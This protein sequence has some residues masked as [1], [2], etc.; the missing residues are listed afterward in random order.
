[1]NTINC[2]P[3]NSPWGE[4][5]EHGVDNED[6]PGAARVFTASHGGLWLGPELASQVPDYLRKYSADGNGVWWEEDCAWVL[7]TAYFQLPGADLDDVK[8]YYPSL[9]RRIRRHLKIARPN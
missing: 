9:Y 3:L 2:V 4:V 1:M 8:E 6:A 5:Q 7:P